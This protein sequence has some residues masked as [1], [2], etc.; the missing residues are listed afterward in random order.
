[1][2]R[3]TETIPETYICNNYCEE[4]CVECQ[5]SMETAHIHPKYRPSIARWYN[6]PPKKV[7]NA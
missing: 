7:K 6:K 4:I 1:M 2:G 3:M 5:Y